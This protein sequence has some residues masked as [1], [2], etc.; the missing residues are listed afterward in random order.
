MQRVLFQDKQPGPRA[1]HSLSKQKTLRQA[2]SRPVPFSLREQQLET[3]VVG[4]GEDE[5]GARAVVQNTEQRG[6]RA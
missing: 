3:G 6:T 4:G 1:Q 5:A 2:A